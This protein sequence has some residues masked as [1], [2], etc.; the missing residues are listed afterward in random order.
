MISLDPNFQVPEGGSGDN[1]P[2]EAGLR[3]VRFR[4]RG[5]FH[6]WHDRPGNR[7]RTAQKQKVDTQRDA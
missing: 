3:G 1:R 5:M 6:P 4:Y 7:C 2:G